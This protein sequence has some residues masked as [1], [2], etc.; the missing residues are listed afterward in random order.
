[1]REIVFDTETTGL[2]SSEDRVIELGALELED[3]VPT[4]RTFHH[5]INAGGRPVHPDAERIHG[6]TDAFLA[7][8]PRFEQ[9]VEEWIAFS[10]DARLVAHNA[11]FD[12]GFMNAE[13]GRL[14]RPLIPQLRVRDTL[15][16]ARQKFPNANNTLDGLCRRF[17][18][19]NSGRDKHGALLDSELL[20][21]VYIELIGGRQT[22]LGLDARSGGGRAAIAHPG[23]RPQPLPPRLGEES[24][25]AHA[26]FWR[27]T[28]KGEA[29]WDRVGAGSMPP[30]TASADRAVAS[31]DQPAPSLPPR[32]GA[33][34][35][36]V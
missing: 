29:L 22:S 19:D 8:K 23:A 5:Y 12:I 20:A 30:A 3:H 7:D 33:R 4:G 13:F 26:A 24:I 36:K 15:S 10:G 14:G 21:E 28:F 1:M 27:E 35:W 16:L 11:P 17:G 9:V 32:R 31:A 2:D 34:R 18:V 25:A 6:I